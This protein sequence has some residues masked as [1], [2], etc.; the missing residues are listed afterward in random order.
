MRPGR[1]SGS[2]VKSSGSG[3]VAACADLGAVIVSQ[4]RVQVVRAL[5]GRDELLADEA[6]KRERLLRQIVR[7]RKSSRLCRSRSRNREPAPG[8]GGT[9]P[10][11]EG[12][13]PR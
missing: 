3:R 9:S 2:S 4:L 12:R 1:G 8:A 13:T 7:L 10:P 6:G 11:W 5:L